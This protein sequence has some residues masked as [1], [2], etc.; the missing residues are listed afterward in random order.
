[1]FEMPAGVMVLVALYGAAFV[2]MVLLLIRGALRGE[3]VSRLDYSRREAKRL[4]NSVAWP[5]DSNDPKEVDRA[6][7]RIVKDINT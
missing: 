5:L 3:G 7:R 4:I 2:G 6:F 1:M